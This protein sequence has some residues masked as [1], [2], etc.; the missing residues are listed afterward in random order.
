MG[1]KAEISAGA[2]MP[3]ESRRLAAFL[4]NSPNE[5]Q[6]KQAL[7]E[8]N[9][10]QKKTPSTALRQA[11]LIKDRLGTLDSKAMDMIANREQEVSIQLLLVAA[12]KHSQLLCDFI[13]DVYIMRQRQMDLALLTAD[14]DNFVLD[15]IHR[16]KSVL[17][18]SESTQ[19][20]LFQVIRRI[21]AET[22]YIENSRTM[23]IT[24]QSLHPDVKHYLQSHDEQYLVTL[25]E[26]A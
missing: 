3:L 1:Y 6:W 13:A 10:L 16:D 5:Q 2:L 18:W 8:E 22:K 4:L 12:I 26:R 23:K 25:L 9:I 17:E 11:R 19:T 7:I 24:P 20:K 14:W 21:L 15:C